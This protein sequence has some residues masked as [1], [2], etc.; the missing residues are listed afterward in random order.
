MKSA[1]DNEEVGAY[2]KKLIL[3]KYPSVRQFGKAYIIA[4]GL[5]PSDYEVQNM[6]NRLSQIVNGKKAIQT[7]D[8]PG[9]TDLLGVSC[10]EILS[11]GKSFVPTSGHITNYEIAFSKD[12]VVWQEYIDREDKLILNTDEY[13]KTI[14]DYAIE[15][16]NYEL[17]KYLMDHDYIWFV[18]KSKYDHHDFVLGYG[19]GTSIKRREI[20]LQDYGLAR[21]MSPVD[22]EEIRLRKGVIILALENEDLDTLITLRAKEIPSF[23]QLSSFV[24]VHI[25]CY[26]YYDEE[27]VDK[28]SRSGDKI[29]RYFSEPYTIKD[30]WGNEHTFIYPFLGE[31]IERLIANKSKYTEQVLGNVIEYNQSVLDRLQSIVEEASQ[32]AQDRYADWDVKLTKDEAVKGALDYLNTVQ[33]DGYVKYFNP[34]ARNVNL[35]YSANVIRTEGRTDDLI[36]A[37]LIRQLNELYDCVLNIKTNNVKGN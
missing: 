9:F 21:Q 1:K 22:G 36:L 10:E 34:V 31:I 29:F 14:L 19:A 15:F 16:K 7:Y 24:N 4:N 37:P 11:C 32:F 3:L 35:M 8:L 12:P 13:N 28:I 26:D 23:F 2:L 18:D 6:E 30:N 17:I 25:S 27:I 33:E 20:S 5:E